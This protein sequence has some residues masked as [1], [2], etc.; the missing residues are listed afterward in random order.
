MKIRIQIN[1]LIFP[2]IFLLSIFLHTEFAATTMFISIKHLFMLGSICWYF[3]NMYRMD[4]LLN[5]IILLSLIEIMFSYLVNNI[6]TI[7]IDMLYG[8]VLYT[9]P[10]LFDHKL[11]T[12]CIEQGA[13]LTFIVSFILLI[14]WR[15]FG[16]FRFWND[17]IIAYLY[18]GGINS[19]LFMNSIRSSFIEKIRKLNFSII[20]LTLMYIASIIILMHTNS[21]NVFI[22]QILIVV[23]YCFK[24]IFKNKYVYI[25]IALIVITYSASII[26]INEYLQTNKEIMTFIS[27][28][29]SAY[30]QKNTVFDGRLVV[31]REV[32]Q[33]INQNMFTKMIGHCLYPNALGIAPHNNFL[34][35]AYEFGFIGYCLFLCFVLRI[36]YIGYKN[37]INGDDISFTA[38][39]IIM[40]YL[41]QLSAE[42]FMIGNDIIVLLPYFYMGIILSRRKKY[43]TKK[44]YHLD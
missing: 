31:Q 42:S 35:I 33:L 14:F 26:V 3:Y 2:I 9:L 21:R 44:N 13:K 10:F 41:I 12:N 18:F 37:I 5:A 29:S 43:V 32:L 28:I 11:F 1:K 30:F 6:S 36:M 27:T 34:T 22:A 25:F 40:G 15:Y 17:N 38:V 8:Y 19:F 16:L 24:N 39:L 23:F 20:I 4:K 7:N